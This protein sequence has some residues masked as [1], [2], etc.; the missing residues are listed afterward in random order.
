MQFLDPS[1]PI[2]TCIKK[3]CKD[4]QAKDCVTC[5]FTKK[6]LIKFFIIAMPA[7]II[8][9]IGAF[10]YAWWMLL[11]FI[12]SM[13][14]YFGFLEIRVMCSHCPHYADQTYKTLTCWANYG[15]PKIWK[16]RPGPMSFW[17]KFFFFFGMAFVFAIPTIAMILNG[18]FILLAIYLA[19]LAFGFTM[20]LSFLCTKCMNFAC[21]FN[22]VKNE[23]RKKFFEN[24]PDVKKA[25]QQENKITNN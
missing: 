10:L 15:A 7:F 21:P 5:H 22:R 3:D 20:L 24:N 23:K 6:H 16:Y 9:G 19:Y 8:G 4:C 13:P 18:T 14:L 25:W 17:E 12:I 2:H 11:P 1:K